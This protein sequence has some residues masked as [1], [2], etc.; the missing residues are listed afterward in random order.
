MKHFS[1]VYCIPIVFIQAKE[2]HIIRK[3]ELCYLQMS[4]KSFVKKESSAPRTGER[5]NPVDALTPP[6]FLFFKES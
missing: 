6:K 4:C 5:S 3:E 1:N 2:I